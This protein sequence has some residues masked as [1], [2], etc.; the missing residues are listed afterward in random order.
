MDRVKFQALERAELGDLL[1]LQGLTYEHIRRALGQLIGSPTHSGDT[2]AGGLLA[3]PALTYNHSTGTLSLSSFS[4]LELTRGG[5]TI[6]NG[7]TATPEARVIRFDSGASGH[8]NHPIDI[9]AHRVNQGV[10]ALYARATTIDEDVSARRAWSVSQNTEIS[11]TIPTRERERVDFTP[12]AAADGAPTDSG[13]FKW[14]LLFT[15]F[16]NNGAL[17]VATYN[18]ALSATDSE[19]Q[20]LYGVGL[21]KTSLD[22]ELDAITSQ[23]SATYGLIQH[24]AHVR[25]LLF[26]IISEGTADTSAPPVANR[27][28][29]PPALS[30]RQLRA[31]LASTN[32]DLAALGTRVTNEELSHEAQ[33]NNA[34]LQLHA[35]ITYDPNTNAAQ[36]N[37]RVFC[38]DPES[39]AVLVEL[40]FDRRRNP[41]EAGT[42][43]GQTPFTNLEAFLDVL[44]RP[45]LG[46]GIQN[47]F[48]LAHILSENIHALGQ[49]SDPDAFAPTGSTAYSDVVTWR[50]YVDGPLDPLDTNYPETNALRI[51][52]KSFIG[53][54]GSTYTESNARAYELILDN[55]RARP[56][57]TPPAANS[58]GNYVFY[59][60]FS[61][62]LSNRSA[63]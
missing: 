53:R 40:L 33:K 22:G 3:Q 42:F 27:W 55:L 25:A 30:L 39:N 36:L 4:Y 23:Q 43:D 38:S 41:T 1:A 60:I 16:V 50:P 56:L 12:R 13:G 32:D 62:E 34:H 51:G 24:L 21:G 10:Y 5:A 8:T 17:S 54:D 59:F 48:N 63:F 58:A 47:P 9:S 35:R 15:Y 37:K 6:T 61:L 44:S 26:Q 11:I 2:G 52:P 31:N 46:F 45:I 57:V 20:A 18:H 7:Q 49:D 19:I 28:S 29:T 14:V